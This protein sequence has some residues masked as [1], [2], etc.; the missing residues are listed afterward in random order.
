MNSLPRA[1][2]F[3]LFCVFALSA[4]RSHPSAEYIELPVLFSDHMV[5]Q[6]DAVI[7]IWGK[8]TPDKQVTA[9]FKNQ[10]SSTIVHKDSTWR[11]FL[12]PEPAGGPYELTFIGTDTLTLQDVMVGEVWVG[13][14]QSNMQWSVQQSANAELEIQRANYP[15]IRLFSVDRTISAQPEYKIPSDGWKP[16]SPSTIPSFSAVAYYFGRTLHD[17]L[18][19]PIGLIHS[20]WGGTPAEAWTSGEMLSTLPD[21][22]ASIQQLQA[23]RDSLQVLSS[24]YDTQLNAWYTNTHS[25]DPGYSG[26]EPAWSS[27]D[28]DLTDWDNMDL[29]NLWED[30]S[31]PGFDG[32]AWFSKTIDLPADW[33]NQ[34]AILHLGPVDDMDITWVNGIEV[35]RTYRYDARRTYPLSDHVLKPGKNVITVRVLDT[36]GGGGIYGSAEELSLESTTA[37]LEAIPLA[38]EWSYSKAIALND[39]SSPPPNP[40]PLQHT[41]SVLYNA[42]IHPL[43]P[44][45]IKGVIWY[46]GESNASRAYQYRSLFSA[47]IDDWRLKWNDNIAFHFVQLANFQERQKNPA[48][49]ETW[50]ELREAQTMALQLSNTGMAVTIDIGEADDIHPRNKQDVGFRLALNALHHNYDSPTVP[51]GPL[52]NSMEIDGDSIRVTFDFADNGLSTSNGRS[53]AGFAIAGED[54]VF[55]WADATIRGNTV[56]VYSNKVSAPV[57]VR[58]GWANNPIVNLQNAEGLPASPFRT[59]DW[60]GITVDAK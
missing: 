1:I 39:L 7:T 22:E 53:P 60:P 13:S 5:L 41:P 29:P 33:E 45:K 14:G 15:N 46:Q 50:P 23:H 51:A 37:E 11:L 35:G 21:F 12:A 6:R 8:A 57:A 44:F 34:E 3:S 20:S 24:S 16:A 55:H 32:I 54:R 27:P 48:E 30:T 17:S 36:G 49:Q 4:C 40:R 28:M 31:L 52:Y 47:L 19:V 26:D 9:L 38:G 10:R 59:D 56:H 25:Q 2:I 18:D 43:I 58:Y 42:M